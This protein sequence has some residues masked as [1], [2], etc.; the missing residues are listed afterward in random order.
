MTISI[1]AERFWTSIEDAWTAAAQT[2]PEAD[3][4]SISSARSTLI[5]PDAAPEDRL[6]A[7]STLDK[8]E[9]AFLEAIRTYLSML[10]QGD[11][12]Q[13]DEHCAQALYAIDTAAIHEV[14]DGSD[15]GFLY[16]RGFVVSQ[17]KKYWQLVKEDVETYG[18]DGAECESFCYI[19]AHYANEKFGEWPKASVSRES[20]SNAEGWK[21][22]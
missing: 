1:S 21:D 20:C 12:A 6:A 13:W 10:T 14:L 9:P 22:A 11:I 5:S 19:A 8:A 16:T 17:G 2:L 15:D 7:V 18:I 3:Q 4:S